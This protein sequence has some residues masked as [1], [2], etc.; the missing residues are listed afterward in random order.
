VRRTPRRVVAIIALLGFLFLQGAVAAHACSAAF[1]PSR[2]AAVNADPSTHDCAGVVG[3]VN[4]AAATLCL[5][6]CNQGDEASNTASSIDV[7]GPAST[8]FLI[9]EPASIDAPIVSRTSIRLAAHSTS[10]PPLSLSQRL[11]I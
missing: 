3:T 4:K 10:P 7:P 6:H 9:V 8:A 11:R 2:G 1:H 5:Q